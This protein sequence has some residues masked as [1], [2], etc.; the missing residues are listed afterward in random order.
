[1]TVPGKVTCLAVG[2]TIMGDDGIGQALLELVQDRGPVGVDY[3]DGAIAGLELLGEFQDAERLLVLDAVAGPGAPGEAVRLEGAD[4]RRFIPQ[5][6][7]PHQVGLMDLFGAARLLNDEPAE[8][9][10]VGVVAEKIELTVGLTETAQGG[11]EAAARLALDQL[12]AWTGG[13]GGAVGPAQSAEPAGEAES[14]EASS[15]SATSTQSSV[16]SRP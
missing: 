2:N 11:L 7:S 6:V 12:A 16:N 10:V 1:M 8:L 5:N 9:V 4:I 15:P 3:V 14:A 13:A